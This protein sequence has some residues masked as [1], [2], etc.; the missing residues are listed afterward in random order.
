MKHINKNNFTILKFLIKFVLIK[1]LLVKHV[2]KISKCSFARSLGLNSIIL[3]GDAKLVMESID[4]NCNDLSLNRVLIHEIG[5]IA[6]EFIR[7]KVQFMLRQCNKVP[8]TLAYAAKSLGSQIWVDAAPSCIF[9]GLA[10]DL[11]G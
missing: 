7:F 11:G 3:E 5:L 6:Y 1:R 4:N 2:N 9:E 8:D 10:L